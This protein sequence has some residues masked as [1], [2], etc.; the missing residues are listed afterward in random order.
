[1]F[2]EGRKR[3]YFRTAA[4][5][6]AFLSLVW[7][8]WDLL[9]RHA[10]GAFSNPQEDM[11]F[12]W[13]VPLFS[14]YVLWT[15]RKKLLS[16]L[17]D[18][19]WA[20]LLLTLPL[21]AVGL[22]GQRGLQIRLSIVSFA[23]LL[24]T[25]P[26]ALFG[27][28]TAKR[29]LFPAAFLLFCLPMATFL[30]VVTVHLRLLASSV[31]FAVLKGFGA[32]VVQTGT[33]IAGADGSFAIDVAD[34]C[35][36]LR[37]LF[38]LMALSAGYAYFNQPTWLRRGLLFASSIPLAI[39][40]NVFRILSICLVA[41]YASSDFATGF[42]HDYSGYVVF[43]VA[44]MLMVGVGELITRLCPETGGKAKS[45]ETSAPA[46]RRRPSAILPVLTPA[47]VAAAM[48]F[49]SQTPKVTVTEAP[50]VSLPE[51]IAGCRSEEMQV[52]EAELSI[53]P[54]DTRFIKRLYTDAN[55]DWYAVSAVI[56]GVSKMSIH[57][58][59]LCLP[60]QG[61]LMSS[62]RDARSSDGISWR[63]ITLE[64]GGSGRQGFAYTF[65]N[66]DGFRTSSHTMRIL[67]DVWDR[68]VFNRID[69]C[70]MTTVN[71][72]VAD[73][74]RLLAFLARLKGGVE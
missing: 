28:A 71:S 68:T 6:F 45:A 36:G 41:A 48:W 1:M 34:P 16:S 22:L 64:K 19:G 56:G 51:V 24:V 20:G 49:Q 2:P 7:G 73:D 11:S 5:A 23:G 27:R 60:G 32:D 33:C 8:F 47:V 55:G 66:Q 14:A 25:V 40:G 35:G 10:P 54:K 63:M 74:D 18:P 4:A 3:L 57:R 30:D 53:L 26:W 70:V 61:Y 39:I 38:A 9:T 37:S 15:E 50:E 65:F 12:G 13:Y 17:G 44:I 42:Y 31:A 67:C 69:R 43:I 62:P 72:S 58:P 59:E 46:R 52:S 29:M 21:L